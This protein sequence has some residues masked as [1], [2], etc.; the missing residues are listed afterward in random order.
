M[1]EQPNQYANDV[2]NR[3]QSAYMKLSQE[4]MGLG[5][6]RVFWSALFTLGPVLL[7]FK[8]IS[9]FHFELINFV[10]NPATL[11]YL[12]YHVLGIRLFFWVH[13]IRQ[14]REKFPDA[15]QDEAFRREIMR[16][17]LLHRVV[18]KL[19]YVVLALV[20][21]TFIAVARVQWGEVELKETFLPEIVKKFVGVRESKQKQQPPPPDPDSAPRPVNYKKTFVG[22]IA[23]RLQIVMT[24]ERNG[25][26]IK[27][28]YH[29]VP[30]RGNL[31]V[32]GT[33]DDQGSFVLKEFN[34]RG[35]QTGVF[36]GRFISETS[37]DGTW[38][39][40]DD[41]QTHPFL[42]NE[43]PAPTD[44][45]SDVNPGVNAQPVPT[46]PRR[47]WED[48]P[49]PPTNE[50]RPSPT[51]RQTPS[52]T[53]TPPIMP[54]SI[55]RADAEKLQQLARSPG[56]SVMILFWAEW[57]APC[58]QLLP[59]FG[60]IASESARKATFIIVDVDSNPLGLEHYNIKGIP[61]MILLVNNEE[62]GRIVGSTSQE[63]ISK[64]LDKGIEN[65]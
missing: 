35:E 20:L 54:G 59:S 2:Q 15:F 32:L 46:H 17:Y 33:V 61:T 25:K 5:G 19:W 51:P 34:T 31:R 27:G 36:K 3:L 26:N 52:G 39:K 22:K 49:A 43:G 29:Y 7:R 56:K 9:I 6:A 30:N 4:Y 50:N 65:R 48:E 28:Y 16:S 10:I 55:T 64:M 60:A 13:Q 57:C 37:M 44:G 23:D 12:V 11:V 14:T 1:M 18:H 41:S 45:A 63:A 21:T 24:L 62:K 40:P 47:E 58:N 53:P 8:V 38:A 42:L